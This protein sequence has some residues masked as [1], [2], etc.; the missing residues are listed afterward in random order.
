[1]FSPVSNVLLKVHGKA[2]LSIQPEYLNT[3][4]VGN[5]TPKL[6]IV[7]G[8]CQFSMVQSSALSELR[9]AM[10]SGAVSTAN[11]KSFS[12]AFAE[13]TSGRGI[14]GKLAHI[15]IDGVVKK[16]LRSLY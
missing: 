4:K 2:S 13:Q 16:D 6:G 8:Q 1:M 11:V 5:K 15:V 7:V 14:K 12:K 10:H 3:A 9:N